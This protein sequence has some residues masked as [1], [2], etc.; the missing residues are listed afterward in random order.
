VTL[1]RACQSQFLLPGTGRRHLA[2]WFNHK[3]VWSNR[4]SPSQMVPRFHLWR[5]QKAVFV[6]ARSFWSTLPRECQSL[7]LVFGAYHGGPL[8]GTRS[9]GKC[10]EFS[11]AVAIL[12]CFMIW[13]SS[14]LLI[15]LLLMTGHRWSW[16]SM[17]QKHQLFERQKMTPKEVSDSIRIGR[18]SGIRQKSAN[19]GMERGRAPG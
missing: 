18:R 4:S 9:P 7:A 1:H 15:T 14:L 3:L 5:A 13:L 16:I 6:F 10:S 12:P 2:I 17:W 19:F 11:P 8:A